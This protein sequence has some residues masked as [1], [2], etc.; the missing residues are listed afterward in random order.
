VSCDSVDTRYGLW[1]TVGLL[2]ITIT[3]K[4]IHNIY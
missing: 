4:H 3:V 2:A 1:D